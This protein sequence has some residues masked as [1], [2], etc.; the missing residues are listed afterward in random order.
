M[1]PY[2]LSAIMI[3]AVALAIYA[4]YDYDKRMKKSLKEWMEERDHE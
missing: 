4:I 3:C 1:N 2:A